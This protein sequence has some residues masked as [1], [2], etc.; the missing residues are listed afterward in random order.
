[1]LNQRAHRC[2]WICPSGCYGIANFADYLPV[3]DAEG[4]TVLLCCIEWSV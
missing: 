1:M 3:F 2:F 4:R